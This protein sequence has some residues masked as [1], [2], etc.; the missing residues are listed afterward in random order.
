MRPSKKVEEP[1]RPRWFEQL[2]GLGA[3][4]ESDEERLDRQRWCEHYALFIENKNRCAFVALMW[5]RLG[6]ILFFNVF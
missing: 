5:I 2:M 4:I 6:T 1:K 3:A